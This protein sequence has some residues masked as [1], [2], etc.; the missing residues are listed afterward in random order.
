MHTWHLFNL[1]LTP[2]LTHENTRLDLLSVLFL[3]FCK[4]VLF[5]TEFLSS[6]KF[7]QCPDVMIS[8]ISFREVFG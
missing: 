4:F 6:V 5:N 2:Y 7:K 1:I 8:H 3:H